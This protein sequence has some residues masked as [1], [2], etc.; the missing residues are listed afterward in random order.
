[1][2]KTL[3][4]ISL[5]TLIIALA[6]IL[7]TPKEDVVSNLK[8][9]HN[10]FLDKSPFKLNKNLS[11]KEKFEMGLPPNRYLSR[12]WELTMNP[13]IGRPTPEN[14]S[15]IRKQLGSSLTARVPGDKA[16]NIWIERGPNNVGGRVR[17]LM[18]DPNDNTNET[19]FAAGVSGGLWKNINISSSSSTWTRVNIPENLNI[20]CMTYDPTKPN[21]FYVGTGESY[22]GGDVNG[23]GLWQS[24]NGGT[25]W[26]RVFGGVTGETKFV[27]NAKLTVNSSSLITGEYQLARANFGP[28]LTSVTGDLVLVNDGVDTVIDGCTVLTNGAE[29]NGN[30]AVVERGS[31]SFVAK[32]KNA[33][34]AGAVAVLVVNDRVGP[35]SA[36]GGV[37]GTVTIP[38]AMISRDA[39]QALITQLGS[40]VNV[41][42]EAVSSSPVA[43]GYLTPGI[44][45]IND[46][47]VRDIGGGNSE[48]YVAAASSRYTDGSPSSLFGVEEY[49]LYRSS[50][51]GNTW[52]KLVLPL[53]SEGAVYTPNDIEIGADN[54]IWIATTR[55][56]SGLGGGVILSSTNGTSYSIE[57]T[58]PKGRR[59]QI[60]VSKSN[61]GR[62]YVL[63]ELSE[64]TNAVQIIRTNDKFNSEEDLPLPDDVDINI[65]ATDFTRGQAFY[66]L[67]IKVD[68]TN[69]NNVFLGGIDL[70]ESNDSGDTWKQMSKWSNNNDLRALREPLVHAD[71]HAITF[72]KGDVTKMLFGN[73]GGVYYSNNSGVSINRRNRGLNVTQFYTVGVAPTSAISGD[74]FYAGAQDNGTQF[75][76]NSNSGI[77]SSVINPT[78]GDG[79]TTLVDQDGSDTYFI[80][81]SVYN[82]RIT[83]RE[84]PSG[85]EIE[86]NRENLNRGD[87]INEGE[88][89]SNLDILYTNY[90][91]GSDFQI[92]RY[93]LS[94]ASILKSILSDN[95]MNSSPTAFKVSPF[96][97]SSTVLLVGLE[98][99]KLLKI[100]GANGSS[101]VWTEIGD[102]NFIGSISDIEFGQT[103]SDIFV[104]IH[105]YG[106]ENIWYSDDAGTSWEVKE[107]NLPDLPVKT[108][109]QNPLN[110]EEVLV[111]TELGVWYTNDFSSTDP[112]WR[113]S[114]NG[115]SNVKVTDLDLRDD[116]TV[117]AAT[118]GRGIF[119][120]KLLSKT[121]SIDE[122]NEEAVSQ[123]KVYPT[124][125]NGD[126]KVSAPI[127]IK[128]GTLNIFDLNGREVYA[129]KV[130]FNSGSSLD[131]SLNV[132]SGIYVI[133]FMSEKRKPY[134]HKVIIK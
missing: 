117:F 94:G 131:I 59:T 78:G 48:V 52:S 28:S 71:H 70:F 113:R 13:E 84:Y 47:E 102:G 22:V 64:S 69:D 57:K 49:G 19:V 15:K 91:E 96:T 44:H 43:S 34:D 7:N 40:G 81:N 110:L 35:P 32:V 101:P 5:L 126:F 88:L 103:E 17:A 3:L 119:S 2:K 107:G 72:G 26:S 82:D 1:M 25:S 11:K 112:T 29:I 122:N 14:I 76:E 98:R 104:T 66:N 74:Y 27:T 46:V 38:S 53:T 79:A 55:N 4:S 41:T 134:T 87:F 111:G 23:D 123:I 80:Y 105:N 60:A 97:K 77:D 100:T 86:V 124:V 99:G 118:Y 20:S 30:I 58:I 42:I 16:S 120:G 85:V 62:I 92:R 33:Q 36:L 89:D 115:M 39:G 90:S 132:S 129:S 95:L 61:P 56:T 75:F 50:S 8:A 121:L 73:D 67:V 109:L 18:F 6:C 37:D 24:T 133:K 125:S 21:V 83:K 63:V 9:K 106:V 65:P 54:T 68:P 130:D 127:D 45:H 12:E 114:F 128:K 51:N 93:D 10:E 31:C 116:N 108:I